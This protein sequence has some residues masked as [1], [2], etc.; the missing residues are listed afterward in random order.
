MS[1]IFYG[2]N[3]DVPA[4]P[5]PFHKIKATE[6]YLRHYDNYLILS[7]IQKSTTDRKEKQQA[8]QE[9][10]ICERKMRWMENH[11]NFE[12]DIALREVSKLKENWKR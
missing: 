12:K 5:V 1:S 4:F 11:P 8:T 3:T 10:T 7:F 6:G 9:L 2:S